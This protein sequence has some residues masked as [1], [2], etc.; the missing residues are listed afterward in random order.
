[1]IPVPSWSA[2]GEYS[3]LARERLAIIYQSAWRR[4]ESGRE[5]EYFP[6]ATYS[7]RE[8]RLSVNF[9][10][11]LSA[12]TCMST[13][14]TR[15]VVTNTAPLRRAE[16]SRSARSGEA[17]VSEPGSGSLGAPHHTTISTA[18]ARG[19]GRRSAPFL[20][21]ARSSL[22]PRAPI[23][24]SPGFPLRAAQ[25]VAQIQCGCSPL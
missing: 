24:G 22:R 10:D 8:T 11:G 1:M 18:A 19:S 17:G 13:L 21:R 7:L 23:P 20:P 2:P 16:R 5:P 12:S 6:H 3:D 15:V 25:R 14:G 4:L 9:D